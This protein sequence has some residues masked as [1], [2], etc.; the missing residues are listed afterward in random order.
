[1]NK[2]YNSSLFFWFFPAEVSNSL[3]VNTYK[4]HKLLYT[5]AAHLYGSDV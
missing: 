5:I 2:Q 1:V 4:V 3:H